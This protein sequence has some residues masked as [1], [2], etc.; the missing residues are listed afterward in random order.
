MMMGG[1]GG[2]FGSTIEECDG[3]VGHFASVLGYDDEETVKRV[4]AFNQANF[5]GCCE[6]TSIFVLCTF[7][8]GAGRGSNKALELVDF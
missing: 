3:L 6:C 5:K 2:R 8:A 7:G 1:V 4:V